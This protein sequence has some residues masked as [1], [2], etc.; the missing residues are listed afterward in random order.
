[1]SHIS[2]LHIVQEGGR[3]AAH[4]NIAWKSVSSVPKPA[5]G[6]Q[7]FYHKSTAVQWANNCLRSTKDISQCTIWHF[8]QI[9]HICTKS[10]IV[11]EY[12][13]NLGFDVIH[14]CTLCTRLPGGH[15]LQHCMEKRPKRPKGCQGPINFCIGQ[16]L[17]SGTAIVW[18]LTQSLYFSHS[19]LWDWDRTSQECA[20]THFTFAQFHY[21]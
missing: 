9:F 20:M 4:S 21:G 8:S 15:T 7:L 2:Q 5:R 12:T 18:D 1:M 16:G 3:A 17:F 6:Q 13:H 19:S 10:H 11:C 14:S